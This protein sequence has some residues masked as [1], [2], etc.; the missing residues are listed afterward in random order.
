MIKW[1]KLSF[2]RVMSVGQKVPVDAPERCDVFLDE[3]MYLGNFDNIMDMD[4]TPCYF[5]MSFSATFDLKGVKT[6]K[7]KSTGNEKLRFTAVLMAG[8]RKVEGVGIRHFGHVFK[9]AEATQ[10]M[11]ILFSPD[12]AIFSAI[13]ELRKNNK[14]PDCKSIC[15]HI[16]KKGLEF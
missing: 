15:T 2:R 12:T 8:V 16:L 10:T 14:I 5:D 13:S 11:E 6:V 1:N 9:M 4:E 7:M 3:M